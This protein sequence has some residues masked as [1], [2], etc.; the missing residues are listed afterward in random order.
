[1]RL[2]LLLA[3]PAL[4]FATPLQDP[5]PNNCTGCVGAGGTAS[6]SGGICGGMVSISVVVESGSCHW[7]TGTDELLLECTSAERCKTTVT[8]RWSNLPATTRIDACVVLNGDKLCL[9]S[10]LPGLPLENGEARPGPDLKCSDQDADKLIFT[11]EAPECGLA[12]EVQASCSAC[13]GDT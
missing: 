2:L 13:A 5:Q 3:G 1:M 8:R 6:T 11:V 10:K 4:L 9:R 7:S 12:A